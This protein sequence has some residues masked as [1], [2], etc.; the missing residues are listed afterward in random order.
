M[1]VLAPRILSLMVVGT[2]DLTYWELGPSGI[3]SRPGW[4]KQEAFNR[5]FNVQHLCIALHCIALHCIALHC[6]TLHY[7]A[8]HYIALH[9]IHYIHHISLLYFALQ[10]ITLRYATYANVCDKYSYVYVYIHMYT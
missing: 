10:Y 4:A 3:T 9:Y 6:I 2:K 5:P 8:L 1:T 7:I